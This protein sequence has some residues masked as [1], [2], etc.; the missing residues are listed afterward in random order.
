MPI[1][2]PQS[3]DNLWQWLD[4][5]ADE[6]ARI[7]GVSQR[8]EIRSALRE[9]AKATGSDYSTLERILTTISSNRLLPLFTRYPNS[10]SEIAKLAQRHT[11]AA[12]YAL[13]ADALSELMKKD[14]EG[15][16]KLFSGVI[17]SV[18]KFALPATVDSALLSLSSDNV[19]SIS[20]EKPTLLM[21][22]FSQITEASGEFSPYVFSAISDNSLST[23]FAQDPNIILSTYSEVAKVSNLEASAIFLFALRQQRLFEL[24]KRD[25]KELV[26]TF[27]DLSKAFGKN[28]PAI[29]YLLR[30]QR[31]AY[32]LEMNPEHVINSFKGFIEAVGKN[33]EIAIP[34][35]F[36]ERVEERF[37][38]DA[39]TL[40]KSFNELITC[41]GKGA[42]K[43]ISLLSMKDMLDMFL[44]NS[45]KVTSLF[46][47]ITR[48]TGEHAD[49][50][51][52]FLSNPTIARML[53]ET[54]DA[55]VKSLG[56]I[57][58]SS[59]DSAPMVFG[60]LGKEKLAA[61]F[62]QNPVEMIDFFSMIGK[63]AE[64]GKKDAF[65]MFAN[66][67]FI[68]GFE[69]WPEQTMENLKKIDDSAG[70]YAGDIFMLFSKERFAQA[71]T[72]LVTGEHLATCLASL[73]NNSGKDTPTVLQ[74]FESDEFTKL[75]IND[76]YKEMQIVNHLRSFAGNDFAKGLE[77]LNDPEIAPAFAEDPS[78]LVTTRFRYY[79]N[80]ATAMSGVRTLDAMDAI[81]KDRKVKELF[82][83]Y[84]R[85]EFHGGGKIG[86]L[87]NELIP[88]FRTY[89]ERK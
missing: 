78:V 46:S 27:T 61:H 58:T 63:A 8:Q 83:E 45:E 84:V 10:F 51:F 47:S 5:N 82:I 33:G 28:S 21:T 6:F 25:P 65:T 37:I 86:M 29:F 60:F 14:L 80:T 74:L 36:N 18:A 73:A 55:I 4:A 1:I 79:V 43:V 66:P 77:V 75:F 15:L 3:F 62:E 31:I 35:I 19:A 71:I 89:L 72:E 88:A 48:A 87:E 53:R 70:S 54:P 38:R 49:A 22:A 30:K 20:I 26:T 59:G 23:L 34:L 56:S 24:F 69:S 2:P 13:N 42:S 50:A 17:G 52:D 12:L 41:A 76:P 44:D 40:G 67:K 32:V 57:V 39:A 68:Q 16:K 81:L 9:I 85:Q 11:N 7:A 64:G